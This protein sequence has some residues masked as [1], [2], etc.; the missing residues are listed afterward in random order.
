M[1]C[2]RVRIRI[3]AANP[4]HQRQREQPDDS[5]EESQC[6]VSASR[7]SAGRLDERIGVRCDVWPI[8]SN[9]FESPLIAA[10]KPTGRS[11]SSNGRAAAA[12]A[13]AAATAVGATDSARWLHCRLH[14]A[15]LRRCSAR[16]LRTAG[17]T[18]CRLWPSCRWRSR[19]GFAVC[20]H[21]ECTRSGVQR[22]KNKAHECFAQLLQDSSADRLDSTR[23]LTM[24]PHSARCC[25]PRLLERTQRPGPFLDAVTAMAGGR[26]AAHPCAS[27]PKRMWQTRTIPR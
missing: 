14:C 23:H 21:F 2:A 3:A 18:R 20:L 10:D 26:G 16:C 24:S 19:G 17:W 27:G 4:V 8:E 25:A 12:A 1:S 11:G 15:T 6:C 7:S 9:R 22:M 5:S 13:A